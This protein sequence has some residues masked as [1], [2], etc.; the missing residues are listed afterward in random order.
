MTQS[1]FSDL[2]P[3]TSIDLSLTNKHFQHHLS[4]WQHLNPAQQIHMAQ[5]V[6]NAINALKSGQL[7]A[8]PTETVYGLGAVVSNIAAIEMIFTYKKRPVTHPLI[9]HVPIGFNI[10]QY[11]VVTPLAQ[12]LID[13]FWPG[14][15]TLIL[16]KKENLTTKVTGGQ[17]SVG[18]R[19]PDHPIA[20]A[21]LQGVNQGV[22]APS[23]NQFG[24]VSPTQYHHV[25]QEFSRDFPDLMIVDGDLAPPKVGIESTIIDARGEHPVILRPGMLSL[26][27]I[28]ARLGLSPQMNQAK[29]QAFSSTQSPANQA[30]KTA[31]NQNTLIN[32]EKKDGARVSGDMAS[33][34]A[35]QTR[36][37]LLNDDW[38]DQLIQTLMQMLETANPNN[39]STAQNLHSFKAPAN[40]P[41]VWVL[42]KSCAQRIQI[43][44]QNY[45]NSLN[46]PTANIMPNVFILDDDIHQYAHDLYKTL[47]QADDWQE[48]AKNHMTYL[49]DSHDLYDFW[50]QPCIFWQQPIQG[51]LSQ[52]I[53]DRLNKA[54]YQTR[55][56]QQAHGKKIEDVL[57]WVHIH[58]FK[59]ASLDI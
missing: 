28:L 37:F 4:F 52:A 15:V 30:S 54:A 25:Q 31:T 5:D 24:R 36:I 53:D 16:D 3:T 11:A 13:L 39:S 47:R 26:E 27:D 10:N 38:I 43:I 14:P 9:V 12:K 6:E 42:R 23:A 46:P 45:T 20:Q 48:N 57:E 22:A 21:I 17:N 33:H 19:C 55:Q 34:Y 32:Q 29:H 35:P 51:P 8:F 18:I 58:H 44:L 1:P 50:Q 2:P 49:A 59:M 7:V 56:L 41:W 40:M